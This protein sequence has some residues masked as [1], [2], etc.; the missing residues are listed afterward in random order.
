MKKL[1]LLFA[2]V[3]SVSSAAKSPVQ[4]EDEALFFEFDRLADGFICHDDLNA[5]LLRFGFNPSEADIHAMVSALDTDGDDLISKIEYLSYRVLRRAT[6]VLE[7]GL[8]DLIDTTVFDMMDSDR[9]GLVSA[10]EISLMSGVPVSEVRAI[11]IRRGLDPDQEDLDF[12]AFVRIHY[13]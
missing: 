4:L 2:L 10:L 7:S 3:A 1:F 6:S 11:H 9:D 8:Q 12:D 5:A 13:S